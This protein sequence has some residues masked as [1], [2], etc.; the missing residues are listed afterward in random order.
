MAASIADIITGGIKLGALTAKG[1]GRVAS[2]SPAVFYDFVFTDSAAAQAWLDF[3]T[4]GSLPGKPS[5]EGSAGSAAKA[6]EDLYI[7]LD[8]A[9]KSS[10]L[11]REYD[12]DAAHAADKIMAV[13][14][15]S[16]S[17]YVIPGTSVKGVL[18]GRAY[19]MLLDMCGDE[20]KTQKFL[21]SV[22]G[23][24]ADNDKKGV[25][26]RL[27]VDEIYIKP[28]KLQAM[29][30]S[31]NRID[32]FT[33]GTVESALFTEEPVWQQDKDKTTLTFRLRVKECTEAEAGLMLLLV[34]DIWLGSLCVGAGKSIGRGVMS[35][36]RCTID[37][38]G[39]SW[40][41]DGSSSFSVE[42]DKEQLEKYVEALGGEMNG[43]Q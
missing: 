18:R 11:V 32:R 20:N 7:T 2:V 14:M 19:K 42:G 35:G 37:Y 39:S 30:H 13:Q 41:I 43:K 16:G 25:K 26:S 27:E 15:K 22:M 24:S 8:C 12:V 34:K 23:W 17:D 5:Y 28:D 31:R 36:R 3:I 4:G 38:R 40:T 10:L 21:G 9:L 29:K 33:G 6:A 1:Y